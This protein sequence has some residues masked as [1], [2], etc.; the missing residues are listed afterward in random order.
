MKPRHFWIVFI[1]AALLRVW[2]IWAAPLWY[3]EAFSYLVG[4]LPL[5]RLI[6]ATAGDVHPPLHYLTV[7]PFALTGIPWLIRIPSLIFSL[8]ALW[9]WWRIL[10]AYIIPPAMEWIGVLMMAFIPFQ[11]YYAQEGR[12]YGLLVLLVLLAYWMLIRRRWVWL[13]V[14]SALILYTHNY[15]MFYLPAL[16]LAGMSLPLIR[17]AFWK[18]LTLS[19]ACAGLAY[20]PWMFVL[21]GQMADVSNSYWITAPTFG[22]VI[23][24]LYSMFA[25]FTVPAW[26]GLPVMISLMT[27]LF[28]IPL[29]IERA[30]WPVLIMAFIPL[31][32]AIAVSFLWKPVLLFRGLAGSAPFMLWVVFMP[33]GLLK[34]RWQ[35]VLAVGFVAPVAL[36]GMFGLYMDGPA[37]KGIQLMDEFSAAI[38]PGETIY[39]LSDDTYITS[40]ANLPDRHSVR[41]YPCGQDRGGLSE[42]T[43]QALGFDYAST[44]QIKDWMYISLV[45]LSAECNFSLAHT[46]TDGLSPTI[47]LTEAGEKS[48]L[49]RGLYK[50]GK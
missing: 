34:V 17:R 39:H 46:L 19:L 3:D 4:R 45:P 9:V 28:F 49:V 32:E 16:W 43:R 10:Q 1:V 33:L 22:S 38:V 50:I 27:L 35:Q 15:G 21:L 11:L 24:V 7:A 6:A 37:N 8:A 13:S 44:E 31:L 2:N 40:I 14:C 42:R 26:A 30:P 48:Y 20:L 36:V 12:M 29:F 25:P 23:Y 41:I 5:D 47:D 18:R